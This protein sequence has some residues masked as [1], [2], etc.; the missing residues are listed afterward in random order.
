MEINRLLYNGALRQVLAPQAFV[1]VAVLDDFSYE[2]R[3]FWPDQAQGPEDGLYVPAPGAEPFALWRVENPDASDDTSQRLRFTQIREGGEPEV[4]QY[5]WDEALG[6][7]TLTQGGG[8]RVETKTRTLD[9]AT[10]DEV[11]T[12]TLADA[13]G[14]VAEQ[15]QTRFADFP[16]G[17]APVERVNDPQGAALA[18]TLTYVEDPGAQGYGRI[19][20]RINPD[21]SWTAYEYDALGRVVQE[22]RPWLDSPP[23]TPAHSARAVAYDFQPVDPEDSDLPEDR[24]SPR[25]ATETVM[26]VVTGRTFYAYIQDPDGSR[27]VITEQAGSQGAAYGDPANLRSVT[28]YFPSQEGQPWSGK[29]HTATRPGGLMDTYAYEYG[30]LSGQIFTQGDGTDLRTFITHGTTD[31]PEGVAFATTRECSIQN[32][33]GHGVLNESYVYDGAGFQLVEWTR[34]EHDAFGRVIRTV[35][36]NGETNTAQWSCCHKVSET[37]VAGVTTAFEYDALGRVASSTREGLNGPIRTFITY[38]AAGRQV[39]RETTAGGLSLASSSQYDGAGRLIQTTD[40]QCLVTQYDYALGGR[41]RTVIQPGG[42]AQVTETF[43]DGR[44][45]QVTGSGAVARYYEFGVNPDGTQ[46]TRARQVRPD[47]PAWEQATTDFLGRMVRSERPGY[48]GTVAAQTFYD[49]HGRVVRTSQTGQ[50]DTLY[51]YDALGRPFRTGLDVDGNGALDL[52]SM[53]R[54]TETHSTFIYEG[55]CVVEP[56]RAKRLCSEQRRRAHSTTGTQK[57]RLTG[58]SGGLVAE[59]ISTDIHGNQTVS[60][61]FLDPENQETR[62]VTDVPGS[63]QDQMSTS[64]FGLVVS[65]T[66]STGVT[67]TFEYDALGRRTAVV[68]PRK[69]A[70]ATTHYDTLGRVDWVADAAGNKTHFDYDGQTGRKTAETNALGQATRYEY[71]TLSR[72]LRTWGATYPVS[73]DYDAYGR[74]TAMRTYRTDADWYAATWPEDAPGDQT[75]WLFDEAT[76]LLTQKL[77]ADG[78]GPSYSYSVDGKL[79]TRTW[80]RTAANGDPL[81]TTYSY[82]PATGELTSID[83]SDDTPDIAFEYDRLG[84]KTTVTDAVGEREFAYNDTLQLAS[85]AITGAYTATLTRHYD[86]LGRNAGFAAGPNYN[87]SYAYDNVGRVNQVAWD[88]EGTSGKTDYSYLPDSDLLAGMASV[89]T[90]GGTQ[91]P[92]AADYAYAPHRNLKTMVKNRVGA[93]RIISQYDYQYNA[94][95]NRTSVVETARHGNSPASTCISTMKEAK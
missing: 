13:Q 61:R 6:D 88:V 25:T 42:A 8:L 33:F 27:T 24:F 26:G 80:A 10:G 90:D 49:A 37:D 55:R 89:R 78:H 43:A 76:G 77:Y 86:A 71:D 29:I 18:Q 83:Y 17:L 4:S 3:F 84:R 58:L 47:S 32:V 64:R 66:S 95:N 51:E 7:W 1:D 68:D 19:R 87:V 94:I 34:F 81:V 69:G 60:R 14:Q 16:W 45:R 62:S 72:I 92:V 30:T 38:D 46:W 15:T 22:V 91:T 41:Q 63:D 36:S 39:A 57:Q 53:D 9:P 59:A 23:G 28:T 56:N 54:I 93:D 79:L 48:G 5:A 85:E 31:S 50:A 44:T 82:N 74:K 75:Q 67:S 52:A 40:P 11:L 70:S 73:Y 65:A 12:E 35:R 20:Q 2:I 21:G